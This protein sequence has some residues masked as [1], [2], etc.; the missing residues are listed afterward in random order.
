VEEVKQRLAAATAELQAAREEERH[1]EQHM[2]ALAEFIR[3][4]AQER[5][6]VR[7]QQQL[8]LARE[9]EAV[10]SSSSDSGRSPLASSSPVDVH[11]S[12]LLVPSIVPQA[13]AINEH[14]VAAAPTQLATKMPVALGN[15]HSAQPSSVGHAAAMV[16]RRGA[17][18]AQLDLL[19]AKRPLPPRG[20]LVQA[21]ME[22]GPLLQNLLVAGPLPRWRNPPQAQALTNAMISAPSGSGASM[23]SPWSTH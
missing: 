14:P 10:M 15:S 9:L 18:A 17:V 5:D 22:A 12:A 6:L 7:E 1:K 13:A 2:K 20:R 16:N 19:A 4:T 8:L 23:G 21:V 11:R 3:H